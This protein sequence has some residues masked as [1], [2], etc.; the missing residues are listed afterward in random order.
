MK[1]EYSS[2][3]VVSDKKMT[4]GILC[5]IQRAVMMNWVYRVLD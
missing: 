3:T 4:T 5:D 2:K 1:G